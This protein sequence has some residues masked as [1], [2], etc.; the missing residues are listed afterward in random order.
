MGNWGFLDR[1]GRILKVEATQPPPETARPPVDEPLLNK[2]RLI[3]RGW[4]RTAIE[5]VLGKPDYL[6][7]SRKDIWRPGN[8]VRPECL[9]LASRVFSAESSGVIRYR[10]E[11]NEQFPPGYFI[12]KVR[13]EWW[14]HLSVWEVPGEN[15]PTAKN[16]ALWLPRLTADSL[17]VGL[18][19][20]VER[21]VFF[22][23]ISLLRITGGHHI[24]GVKWK[25]PLCCRTAPLYDHR[26]DRVWFRAVVGTI[27]CELHGRLPRCSCRK[28]GVRVIEPLSD[29]ANCDIGPRLESVV[30]VIER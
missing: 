19:W 5:R 1:Q 11:R 17:D 7:S 3:E 21:V 4:T 16:A 20:T 14:P 10:S 13:G 8:T 29:R 26:P 22:E 12:R 27:T 2:A 28:H 24:H 23:G 18:P 15:V 6:D 9:Y 25:C 30:W